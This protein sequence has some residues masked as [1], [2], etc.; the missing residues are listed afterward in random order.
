[1][2]VNITIPVF[3]EEARLPGSL[4]RVHRFLTEHCRFKFEVVIADN[5]S[6]DQTLQI[7]RSFSQAYEAVRVVHLDQK[8]RGRALKKVWLESAADIL[9][10]MD[11]DLSTDLSA[12][13]PLIKALISGGFDLATGSRLLANAQVT[14]S[15]TREA[16][17]RSYN[18]LVKAFFGTR[19]SDAQCGFKA[20]TKPAAQELLPLIENAGWFFDTE[21][22]TVAEK[23]GYRICDVPVRWVEDT[24][25][26]VKVL[27]T[28]VADLQGLIRLK[29][30]FWS[31]KYAGRIPVPAAQERSMAR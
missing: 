18:L 28:A 21:L 19:F 26:R 15:W 29:R 17:S 7:A 22:L 20:I 16:V 25:S 10:Y 27:T 2:L 11:V 30:N 3:S 1:M 23:L 8:G 12:F 31:G 14:R 13:S 24:D 6:T 4:P 9:S 5:A